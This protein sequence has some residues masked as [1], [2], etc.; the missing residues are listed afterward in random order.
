MV[1]RSPGR[2]FPSLGLVKDLGI[3]GILWGKFLFHFFGGL[4]QGRGESELSNVGVI[5]PEHLEESRCVSLLSIDSG[6]EFG[7]VLLHGME[8]LQEIPLF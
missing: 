1:E 7:V 2:K 6:S 4:G 5:L 8:I 3:L